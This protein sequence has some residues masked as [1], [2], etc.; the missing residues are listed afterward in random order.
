MT[1]V[2]FFVLLTGIILILAA[3]RLADNNTKSLGD[4]LCPAVGNV[5][6]GIT[7]V[8]RTIK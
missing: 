4:S 2:A 1:K 5:S 7:N 3:G 8:A 6:T